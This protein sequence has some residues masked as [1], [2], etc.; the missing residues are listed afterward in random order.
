MS[1]HLLR[2]AMIACMVGSFAMADES[3]DKAKAALALAKAQRERTTPTASKAM[4]K[5][6]VVEGCFDDL[7]TAHM[8]AKRLKKP[9]VLWVGMTCKEAGNVC[10]SL[11]EDVVSCHLSSYHG[12]ATA[13]IVVT[14]PEGV[15][16]RVLKSEIDATTPIGLRKR[17]G[18]SIAGV[19]E[20]VD[21]TCPLRAP[22]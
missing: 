9:L 21:G 11:H 4:P 16:Y 1:L 19:Q 6:A 12:S 13:R 20:C 8:V 17:M 3:T 2:N 10:D 7:A 18:L 5:A 14:D 15:E 22:R